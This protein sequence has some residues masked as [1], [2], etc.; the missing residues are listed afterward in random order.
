MHHGNNDYNIDHIWKEQLKQNG[1]LPDMMDVVE[2][3]ENICNYNLT[4]DDD[5]KNDPM[6]DDNT[7]VPT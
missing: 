1:N 6:D 2:D 3:A 5:S 4:D 7:I